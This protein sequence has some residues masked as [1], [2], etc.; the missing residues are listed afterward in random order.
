M[1]AASFFFSIPQKGKTLNPHFGGQG[2]KRYSGR[3]VK[4]PFKHHQNYNKQ[5]CINRNQVIIKLVNH[6]YQ[7]N[8]NNAFNS[9]A[10]SGFILPP[11]IKRN[12]R[13]RSAPSKSS[14]SPS[15]SA[16]N[17]GT[18]TVLPSLSKATKV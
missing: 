6:Y 9:V 10:S 3:R 5:C 14:F 1:V 8:L 18:A 15:V 17:A 4:T 11:K 12:W 16:I 13:R 7:A 2:E